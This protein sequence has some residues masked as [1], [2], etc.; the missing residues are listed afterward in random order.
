MG[1]GEV[2]EIGGEKKKTAA[3]PSPS[4]NPGPADGVATI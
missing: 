4:A 2:S 1:A 3:Y